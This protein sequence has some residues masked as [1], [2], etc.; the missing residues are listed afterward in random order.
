MDI[1]VMG[2][3]IHSLLEFKT[4]L[5]EMMEGA[6]VGA[7]K[8]TAQ[9]DDLLL[10]KSTVEAALPDIG[11]M[12]TDL[13]SVA[14]DIAAVKKDLAPV[15][16]WVA[17]QQKAVA[18]AKEKAEAEEKLKTEA[19]AKF[20]ADANEAKSRADASPAAHA[21]DV[22]IEKSAAPEMAPHPDV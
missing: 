5:E 17:A 13:S 11:K 3:H 22:M 4:K 19:A 15:L 12:V 2:K 21:T 16:E 7:E 1:D 18:E 20:L 14:D 8:A 9:L 10:F 6:G